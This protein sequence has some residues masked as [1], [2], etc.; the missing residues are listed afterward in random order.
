M[1]TDG[2]PRI[3]PATIADALAGSDAPR[4]TVVGVLLAGGTSSRFGDRNKLL[5]D[6]DGE[7]LV[8]HA[9][10]TLLDADLSEVVAVLGCEAESVRAALSGFDLRFVTNPAYDEGLSTS[11]ARGVEA[12]A[13]A[14]AVLV[15]PGDMPRVSPATATLLVD[16][17][18]AD[19]A[20]AL[21]AAYDGRRGN[22]VLFD[23]AHFD[24]LRTVDGDVGGRSVL[25]ESD[26]SALVDTDDRGVVADV[27]TPAD[28]RRHR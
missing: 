25:L 27:D 23:R 21:A 13:E 15:L 19:L 1:T 11:V 12:A 28:L 2:L 10:R 24:A 22:P 6:L 8:R 3:E 4:P 9:A 14:D 17:Y 16:A 18:R 7:A 5:A 20:T 26:R